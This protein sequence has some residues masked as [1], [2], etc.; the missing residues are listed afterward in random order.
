MR[1]EYVPPAEAD[2]VGANALILAAN[3]ESDESSQQWR[4]FLDLLGRLGT[5]G[6]L[7]GKVVAALGGR[8]PSLASLGFVVVDAAVSD[9]LVLGREVA[10]KARSIKAS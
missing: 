3:K 1:K 8:F 4:A 7:G 2:V 9:S 5:E 10:E 6:R